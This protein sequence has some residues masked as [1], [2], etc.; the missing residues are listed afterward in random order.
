MVSYIRTVELCSSTPADCVNMC[1][2]KEIGMK[3]TGMVRPVDDLG[4]VVLP[5]EIRKTL[6][7]SPRDSVE[8]FTDGHRIVLQ[9]YQ[10][11]CLFCGSQDELNIFKG[12]LVCRECIEMMHSRSR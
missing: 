10:P 1:K 7:I 11:G 5:I 3:S 6:E 4:R 2:D 8:I 9:K 12:K